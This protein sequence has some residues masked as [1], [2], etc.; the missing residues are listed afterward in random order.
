MKQQTF[1]DMEYANRKRI[2]KKEVFLDAM[3]GMIPWEKW[4]GM[5]TPYYPS[6]ERGRPPRGIETMLRMY[7]LQLWFN[8]SD[9]GV[10]DTI[11]DSY[12]MRKFMGINFYEDSA[13]DATTLLK[14]RRLLETHE[15]GKALFDELNGILEEY[16]YIL[17]GGTIV[18]ATIINAPKSTKNKET[19]RDPE[20]HST[21]KNN[22]YFFG[23][24]C[25]TGVDAFSGLVHTIEVTAANEADVAVAHKLFR[26]DDKD[27]WG[28]A[29]YV[30]IENRDEIKGVEHLAK[31][32]FHV[33]CRRSS[34]PKLPEGMI[35]WDCEIEQMKSRVRNKVE[36]PY[37]I[38]KCLFGYRKTVYRGLAKNKNR[39]YLL[40]ASS[41]LYML[42]MAGRRTLVPAW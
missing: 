27:G 32:A 3:E 10:E 33:N 24:K 23:M 1:S 40:F 38:V 7:L 5:I 11:Y 6:G 12:A 36:H 21:K 26:E 28:D 20:M 30:G 15:L 41:N 35:N 13:P 19:A 34:L 2:T 8:L 4:I 14:F 9:E 37:R 18:D 25:H 42:I 17:R 39:L 16:G 29:G 22:T 31:M